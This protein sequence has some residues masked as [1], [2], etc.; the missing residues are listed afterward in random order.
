MCECGCAS[1]YLTVDR[2]AAPRASTKLPRGALVST[3]SRDELIEPERTIFVRLEVE[4]G[5]LSAVEIS[6]VG[7]VTPLEFPPPDMLHPPELSDRT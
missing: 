1:F 5:W 6:W 3:S 2:T 7:D 4:D